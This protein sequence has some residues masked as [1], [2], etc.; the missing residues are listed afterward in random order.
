MVICFT[1]SQ[2]H[3]HFD[4]ALIQNV[5]THDTPAKF[6]NELLTAADV[7]VAP[8]EEKPSDRPGPPRP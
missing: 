8:D 5:A 4:G 6:L 2:I 3:I 1:C 7:P